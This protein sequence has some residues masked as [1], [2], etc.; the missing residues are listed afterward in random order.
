M[1]LLNRIERLSAIAILVTAVAILATA[2]SATSDA[3]NMFFLVATRDLPDPLFAETV[4][5]MI[6]HTPP[7]LVVGLIVNKPTDRRL[8]ELLPE[9]PVLK[10]RSDDAYFGGP[11]DVDEPAIVFRSA[12]APG[13]VMPLFD[14]V[15]VSLDPERVAALLKDRALKDLRLYFGRAQWSR[16]QLHGEM[17][18]G[19]W[20]VVPADPTFVFSADPK[21]VW[22]A[23]VE[24]AELQK[25]AAFTNGY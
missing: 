16:D 9:S 15:Y 25:A 22:R 1:Q 3:D 18:R 12:E 4:I 19:S 6:P 2:A 14:G 21:H 20:Y 7:P 5:L 11:V 24:R 10:N 17:L 13:H 23:L 8:S